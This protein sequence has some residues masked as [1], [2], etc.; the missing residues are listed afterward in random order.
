MKLKIIFSVFIL[1]LI[2]TMTVSAQVTLPCEGTDID[3]VACP[4][5]SWVIALV[6]IASFLAAITLHRRKNS[7]V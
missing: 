4:L 7:S 5:D 3:S 2:G 1:L 6:I